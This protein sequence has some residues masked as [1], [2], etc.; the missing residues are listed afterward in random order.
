MTDAPNILSP[1]FPTGLPKMRS[2]AEVRAARQ[3]REAPKPC[4]WCG[5]NPPLGREVRKGWYTVGCESDD[6]PICPQ[7][8]AQTLTEAWR[9]WNK[10][11]P[12]LSI[13]A[14]N[15]DLEL[16]GAGGIK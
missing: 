10:R 5:E 4:P 8:S 3:P 1:S 7:V 12:Q 11:A 2:E 14:S 9:L 15:S 16:A 13:V 6:C